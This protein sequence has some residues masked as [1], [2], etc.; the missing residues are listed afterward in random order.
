MNHT[1][2]FS[3]ATGLLLLAALFIMPAQAVSVS[4]GGSV[5]YFMISTD[6]ADGTV[7]FDGVD[8][9]SAPVT[10]WVY[11]TGSPRHT[12]VVEK[13]GYQTWVQL[14]TKNP[15]KDQT[16]AVN[17]VLVPGV[18][19]G[20]LRV[21]SD[22]PGIPVTLDGSDT[23]NVPATFSPVTTG[24]HTIAS[25]VPGYLPF[26]EKVLVVETGTTTLQAN[27][28]PVVE[29]GTLEVISSP[30][31]ADLYA[32][33]AY[34]GKTPYASPGI[35]AGTYD[36]RLDLEGYV[37]WTGTALVTGDEVETVNVVLAPLVTLPVSPVTSPPATSITGTTPVTP[38]PTTS[39]GGL[40][41]VIPVALAAIAG[42]HLLAGRRPPRP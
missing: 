33:G 42:L 4:A 10:V 23:M 1:T 28:T 18:S 32:N 31:G 29:A 14:L 22:V 12:V 24:Y 17:A 20:V 5:G 21:E 7:Y 30:G 2:S 40:P 25:L 8:Q 38:V 27:L 39:A 9:G 11:T 35:A 36:I 16:I 15:G 26:H 34:L 13:D 19:Y 37:E 3:L 6:P 41:F